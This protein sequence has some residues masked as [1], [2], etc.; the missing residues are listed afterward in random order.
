[1]LV[2]AKLTL[3]QNSSFS[4]QCFSKGVRPRASISAEQKLA[5]F[6]K[7]K[8]DLS[9]SN[10]EASWSGTVKLLFSTVCELPDITK[11]RQ[12]PVWRS[13]HFTAICFIRHQNHQSHNQ[14]SKKDIQSLR[15]NWP[16]HYIG[17]YT[18]YTSQTHAR[19]V[20]LHYVGL[21]ES[22]QAI[23]HR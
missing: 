12:K 17:K 10:L 1:M 19:N 7:P 4:P 2:K 23:N 14:M 5:S 9:S 20:L 18:T 22:S 21:N 6:S 15:W 11:H 16:S 3:L 8:Q 13:L